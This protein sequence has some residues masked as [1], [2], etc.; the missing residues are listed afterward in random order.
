M[1]ELTELLEEVQNTPWIQRH[2]S[3]SL[4]TDEKEHLEK[5]W[6][7]LDAILLIVVVALF[8]G[9]ASAV[10]SSGL[11]VRSLSP[12]EVEQFSHS[13][14]WYIITCLLF[15]PTSVALYAAMALRDY[16][17]SGLEKLTLSQKKLKYISEKLLSAEEQLAAQHLSDEVQGS[18]VQTDLEMDNGEALLDE[19]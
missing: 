13:L 2:L 8:I 12:E 11:L 14:S 6:R 16:G 19:E 4:S 7:Q 9:L 1:D 17:H 18:F 5:T 15:L 10:I 3:F